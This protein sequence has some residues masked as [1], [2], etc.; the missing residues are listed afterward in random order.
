MLFDARLIW[1]A[2][3][4]G[5][6]HRTEG[7]GCAEPVGGAQNRWGGT[8]PGGGLCPSSANPMKNHE[9]LEENNVVLGFSCFFCVFLWFSLVRK[10]P[11]PKKREINL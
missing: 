10:P 1:G 7:K 5:G 6:L 9:K 11:P 8:E 3:K 2:Y 4:T